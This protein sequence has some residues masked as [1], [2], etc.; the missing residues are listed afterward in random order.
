VKGAE[1]GAFLIMAEKLEG[2]KLK[3]S[4]I[5]EETGIVRSGTYILISSEWSE[6]LDL[7]STLKLSGWSKGR[8]F[9]GVVKKYHFAGGPA[10]HGQS[11]RERHRGSSGQTTTPGRV[12]PG[13]RMAGRMGGNK[14]TLKNAPI[15]LKDKEKKQVFVGVPVPG[16]FGSKVILYV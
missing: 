9:A 12:Y 15:L 1:K 11:D 4:Q 13:K 8:G 10:T 3:M 16:A 14:V 6:A 7:A 2:K 5:F